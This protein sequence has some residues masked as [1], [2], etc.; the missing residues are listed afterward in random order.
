MK[1]LA[2][3]RNSELFKW[4]CSAQDKLLDDSKMDSP[5]TTSPFDTFQQIDVA[6]SDPKMIEK[7]NRKTML[8]KR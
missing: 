1:H 7:C 4:P 6:K 2:F 8:P 3:E 5:F